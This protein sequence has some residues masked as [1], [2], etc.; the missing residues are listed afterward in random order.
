[1]IRLERSGGGVGIATVGTPCRGIR[2]P[3]LEKNNR[4]VAYF[5]AGGRSTLRRSMSAS[6]IT[7][8][9]IGVCTRRQS[10][11][12]HAHTCLSSGTR[13]V[14]FNRTRRPQKRQRSVSVNIGVSTA[15]LYPM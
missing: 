7:P 15:I 9:S 3:C 14:Q 11:H 12:G 1:M 5:G 8:V 4:K 13:W 2:T 10:G 6:T